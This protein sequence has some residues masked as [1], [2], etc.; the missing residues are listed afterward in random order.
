[1]KKSFLSLSIIVLFFTFFISIN[2]QIKLDTVKAQRFDT[3][4]MWSFDYPPVDYLKA[5]YG[6]DVDEEWFEDVRLSALRLS[7][8]TASFVSEDGLIMTNHH[9][10]RGIL[11]RLSKEGEDLI[12]DGF[13]AKTLEEERKIPNYYADQLVFIKDVTEDVKKAAETGSTPEEKAKNKEQKIKE[14]TDNLTKETGLV[15]QVVSLFNGAKYSLYGYK[16]YND[17]RLV[18]APDMQIAYFGGDFDNFTYPR[19][20]LDFT[21]YRAY[22]NDKPVKVYN[23]FKFSLKG[24]DPNEPIFTVGNPGTTQRL[25]TIAQLEYMRDV[26]YRNNAFLLDT[27]YNALEEL[28]KVEPKRADEFEKIRVNIGNSQ[29]VITT[30][31]KGLLDPYLMA[32]KK[33][34]QRKLQEAVWNNPELKEKYGTVW[35]NIEKTQMEMRNYGPKIAAYT[36]N[37]RFTPVYFSIAK[38]LIDLAKELSKPENERAPEYKGEKLDSTIYSIYPEKIDK[39]LENTKLWIWADFM[40]MNLGDNDTYIQ[41][42]FGNKKGKAAGE[43]LLSKSIISD[44]DKVLDLA[45]K[46]ADAI[47]NSTDPLIQFVKESQEKL[48]ELQKL[49]RE[50]TNTTQVYDDLLGQALF[51]VYGTS[52]PPDANFTLRI[53]D[54]K[55]A[56]FDYNGTKAPLFTTFYGLYDRWYSFN[57][58]YPWDLHERWTKIPADFDLSTPFNFISTN[59]IVGGNSG[60]AIINKNAEVVGLA[61]DGNMDSIVGNFIYMP[62]NNRCVGVDARAIVHS[63]EK[64]YKAD[65]IVYE[66][67]EGKMK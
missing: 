23:F 12:K 37:P 36:I 33:D 3:G 43:Y 58:E 46:G 65:R 29:K 59:D 61:F 24:I 32:R 31:Y 22:E 54:G 1:M 25:K 16:R 9:C 44:R 14:L 50:V 11:E 2:A 34:F 42:L 53:S 27:Y 39:L 8:C 66:L 4:K 41:N 13:Y 56:S 21:F 30:I 60:S 47:I 45:K 26:I 51:S 28:K 35:E 67:K 38:K 15:A 49:A 5:T 10:A 57:K 17:I 20:N 40:R 6:I 19:Y 52:I 7:N 63:A 62:H 18:F 55:L 48:P 64:I